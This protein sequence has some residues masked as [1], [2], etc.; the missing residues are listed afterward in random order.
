MVA[1]KAGHDSI[2]TL[3]LEHNSTQNGATTATNTAQSGVSNNSSSTTDTKT[4]G[5]MSL[6]QAL[7]SSLG[8]PY[9]TLINQDSSD[10]IVAKNQQF[11]SP[12][13]ETNKI[14]DSPQMKRQSDSTPQ[15]EI[16]EKPSKDFSKRLLEKSCKSV[17]KYSRNYSKGVKKFDLNQAVFKSPDLW[18]RYD[19]SEALGS[20][21]EQR[22]NDLAF[23]V[24]R[25]MCKNY[26]NPDSHDEEPSDVD[27]DNEKNIWSPNATCYL[28]RKDIDMEK[29]SP[30]TRRPN[31]ATNP[32][33]RQH[34]SNSTHKSNGSANS[35]AMSIEL[36]S[37]LNTLL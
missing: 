4:S 23:Q 28:S 5:F 35:G 3:I 10:Q 27:Q 29:I 36:S 19:Q 12:K 9:N 21:D 22:M 7:C 37:P 30:S 24:S 2:A 25:A 34:L 1:K 15:A 11:H 26:P 14:S 31:I 13:V 8:S 20:D 32:H 33:C 6:S 17:A 16:V 18:S